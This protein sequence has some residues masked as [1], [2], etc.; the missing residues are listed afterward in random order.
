MRWS[1]ARWLACVLVLGFVLA[2]CG[3]DGAGADSDAETESDIDG[4]GGDAVDGDN[5]P[6]GDDAPAGNVLGIDIPLPPGAD[7]VA[8][9]DGPPFT[10]VQFIVP[11][12]QQQATISFYQDWTGAQTDEYL[13]TEGGGGGVTWQNDPPAGEEKRIIAILSP[14]DGDDFAAVTLTV[15]PAE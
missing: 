5:A 12:D 10:V 7:A 8:T 2:G 4:G 15:G 14:L 11:L 1:R 3:D 9:S 13:R 6:A